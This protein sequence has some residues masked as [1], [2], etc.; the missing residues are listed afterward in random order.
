MEPESKAPHVLIFPLPAQGHVNSMLNLAQL[1]SLS[2]LNITFLNTDHN[3][4]CLVLDTDI[5]VRFACFP[6]FQFKSIPDGLPAD[7][8]QAGYRYMEVFDSIKLV[9]EPL[10]K[11]MM[12]SGQ[13]NSATGQSVTC[14][15][16]DG[17]LSF[18]IDVGNELG[19]PVIHFHTI[20]ACSFWAY[21]CIQDMIEAGEL[22][23][24]GHPGSLRCR[25]V[26][27]GFSEEGW[28]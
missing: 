18:P 27:G 8:Q 7:H 25:E 17:S 12:Y 10:F 6:G 22:P 4:N 20:S 19:I 21:C 23:I 13:L 14:I 11:E 24:R 26:G 16:A 1:L 28:T 5:L 15:I 2:G 9:T 3:H